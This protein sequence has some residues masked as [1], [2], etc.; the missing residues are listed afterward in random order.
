[1]K[2]FSFKKD[3]YYPI[4]CVYL[5]PYDTVKF[6]FIDGEGPEGEHYKC[7]QCFTAEI[8]VKIVPY[9]KI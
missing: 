9:E 6:Y 1:M 5:L 8:T 3:R 4:E 2:K 7:T